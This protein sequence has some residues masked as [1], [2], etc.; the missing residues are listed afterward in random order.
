MLLN[1]I[2]FLQSTNIY[3]HITEVTISMTHDNV[4]LVL[5]GDDSFHGQGQ[6]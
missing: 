3:C 4:S 5:R 2:I 1:K 6:C